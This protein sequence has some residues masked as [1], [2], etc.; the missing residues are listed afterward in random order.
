MSAAGYTHF[1]PGPV[2]CVSDYR[3]A[4]SASLMTRIVLGLVFN[5]GLRTMNVQFFNIMPG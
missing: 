4:L 1:G 3:H 2:K 5:N